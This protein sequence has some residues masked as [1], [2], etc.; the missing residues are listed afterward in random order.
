MRP[1]LDIGQADGGVEGAA[2]EKSKGG[3]EVRWRSSVV[4]YVIVCNSIY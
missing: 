4:G 1:G 2:G 3:W